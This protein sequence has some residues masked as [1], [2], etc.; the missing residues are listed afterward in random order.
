MRI[1]SH[2][3]RALLLSFLLGPLV[4]MGCGDQSGPQV[5]IPKDLKD[6]YNSPLQEKKPG[7]GKDVKSIKDRS[8]PMDPDTK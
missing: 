3:G 7:K 8:H 1:F 2:R 4:L 5:E 6:K